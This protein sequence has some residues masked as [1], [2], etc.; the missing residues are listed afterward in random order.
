[1]RSDSHYG[2]F[3]STRIRSQ[4]MP[5]QRRSIMRSD[6]HSG[7]YIGE[8]RSPIFSTHVQCVQYKHGKI[9]PLSCGDDNIRSHIAIMIFKCSTLKYT[10]GP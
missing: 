6:R 2:R 5:Y 8:K 9:T 1:M 10:I 7:L 4:S 3:F